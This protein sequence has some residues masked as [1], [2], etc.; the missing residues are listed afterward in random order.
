MFCPKCGSRIP[1][2]AQFCP[3]CGAKTGAQTPPVSDGL[4]SGTTIRNDYSSIPASGVRTG[5]FLASKLAPAAVTVII[6]VLAVLVL[7][8][9]GGA[10]KGLLSMDK[11]NTSLVGTWSSESGSEVLVFDEDGT[12][13]VPFTYDGAWL[14]S[15][16]RY[17]IRRDDSSLVLSS[18]RGNIRSR[19]YERAKSKE[20]ALENEESYYVKGKVLIIKSRTYERQ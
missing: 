9:I 20:E 19:T 16:D 8:K 13:S 2:G 14:E 12:C 6:V 4:S 18:S 15:C 5:S 10:V 7:P 1:D 17:T 11:S 3:K